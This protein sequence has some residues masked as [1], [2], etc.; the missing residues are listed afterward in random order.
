MS[1]ADEAKTL[2]VKNYSEGQEQLPRIYWLN[3]SKSAKT[4]GVFFVKLDELGAAPGSPWKPS[5][6]FDNEAAFETAVLRIAPITYRNQ[7]FIKD[8]RDLKVWLDAW[9]PGAS[10]Y[11]E[12]LCFAEGIDG[13]VIWVSKGLTGKA[14]TGKG[15]I[16][17]TYKTGLLREGS[18]QA[19]KPLNNWAF[20]VPVASQQSAGKLVYTDTGH[21]STVTLPALHLPENPELDSFWVGADLY[22]RGAEVIEEMAGWSKERRGNAVAET[23]PPVESH[24]VPWTPPAEGAL[25]DLPF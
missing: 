15:G 9:K 16:L 14:L 5:D 18:R 2:D 7:P 12:L 3:G 20:W 23:P 1:F 22:K 10:I 19:G 24:H 4:P 17:H 6:R 11:T 21:G 13:P 25:D 8:D